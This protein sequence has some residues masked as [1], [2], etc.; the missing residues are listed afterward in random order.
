MNYFF[1]V[2]DFPVTLKSNSYSLFLR[3]TGFHLN[4][5]ILTDRF[6]RRSFLKT[7]SEHSSNGK[8]EESIGNQIPVLI[9]RIIKSMIV[10]A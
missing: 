6:L 4:P 1:F 5:D 3:L 8:N 9:L 2:L 10:L 7:A